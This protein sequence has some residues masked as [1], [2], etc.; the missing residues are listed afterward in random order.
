MESCEILYECFKSQAFVFSLDYPPIASK[1]YRESLRE[2]VFPLVCV[3]P[4]P[5]GCL[6]VSLW[7]LAG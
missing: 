2:E 6:Q 7:T 1:E 5:Q 3:G 4:G